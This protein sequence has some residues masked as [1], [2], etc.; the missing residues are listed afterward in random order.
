MRQPRT[1]DEEAALERQLRPFHILW[2]NPEFQQFFVGDIMGKDIE[3]LK[4]ISHNISFIKPHQSQVKALEMCGLKQPE[5]YEE[6]L[7]ALVAMQ[8]V[9]RFFERKLA[10]IAGKSRSYEQLKKGQENE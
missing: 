4:A 1:Q 6:R 3:I 5:T 7:M 9:V 2:S 8:A 10:Y